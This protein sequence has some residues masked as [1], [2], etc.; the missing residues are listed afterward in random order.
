MEQLSLFSF[1]KR[2]EITDLE[3]LFTLAKRYRVPR[4]KG[5]RKKPDALFRRVMAAIDP[6]FKNYIDANFGDLDAGEPAI[7]DV[8]A[9]MFFLNNEKAL[10]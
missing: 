7:E 1:L 6:V 3:Q 8:G 2:P 5:D 9:F 4:N 10:A